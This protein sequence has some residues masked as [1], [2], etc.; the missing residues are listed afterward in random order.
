MVY[1]SW[2]LDKDGIAWS[3]LR[4]QCFDLASNTLMPLSEEDSS[5]RNGPARERSAKPFDEVF[6]EEVDEVL[7]QK[8]PS[9]GL[10]H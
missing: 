9:T 3:V 6:E 5:D 8:L 4:P 1:Q 10:D 7:S 2:K